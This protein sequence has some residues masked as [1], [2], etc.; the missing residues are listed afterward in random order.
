M[1]RK[2]FQWKKTR[3]AREYHASTYKRLN[4]SQDSPDTIYH[5]S[6]AKISKLK[7]ISDSESEPKIKI[8]SF[9]IDYQDESMWTES[10]WSV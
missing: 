9:K 4:I 1:K 2:S 6:D 8:N 10:V 5:Q 3:Q 7:E